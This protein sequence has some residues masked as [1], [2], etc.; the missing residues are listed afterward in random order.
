MT[1]GRANPPKVLLAMAPL[2]NIGNTKWR[3]YSMQETKYS[4]SET[5]YSKSETK[6]SKSQ[7]F[8]SSFETLEEICLWEILHILQKWII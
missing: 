1:P 3:N 5:K 8:F 6:Y 7:P 4:K 2:K